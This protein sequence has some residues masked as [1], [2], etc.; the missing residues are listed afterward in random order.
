MEVER[1]KHRQ[2]PQVGRGGGSPAPARTIGRVGKMSRKGGYGLKKRKC[3]PTDVRML[4]TD[5][6][7][8]WPTF[9]I[10]ISS[11]H[12]FPLVTASPPHSSR[13]H[14]MASGSRDARSSARR[15]RPRHSELMATPARAELL[16]PSRAHDQG[17]GA[18][19][20]TG[21]GS[22]RSSPVHGLRLPVELAWRGSRFPKAVSPPPR[23]WGQSPLQLGV[24]A[25]DGAGRCSL[26]P[27]R[28]CVRA[29]ASARSSPSAASARSSQ[30]VKASLLAVKC[31]SSPAARGAAPPRL[32]GGASGGS[33]GGQ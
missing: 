15:R 6:Q 20:R 27:E 9:F 14:P 19:R 21:C 25:P 31:E 33:H 3:S 32:V 2:V 16:S 10:F 1:F 18:R 29:T 13:T 30:V 11:H 8:T 24:G 7:T 22:L 23:D 4:R 28:T 17:G 12:W 5:D 26:W